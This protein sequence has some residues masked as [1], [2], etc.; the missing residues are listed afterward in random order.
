ME[1]HDYSIMS[2]SPCRRRRG[3]DKRPRKTEQERDEDAE[4]A[5]AH[6]D[7]HAYREGCCSQFDT[8][9]RATING[10]V[11]E[12]VRVMKFQNDLPKDCVSLATGSQQQQKRTTSL[13][14]GCDCGYAGW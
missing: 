10:E 9:L 12:P 11:V 5:Y 4:D 6:P 14:S 7:S 1:R 8:L 13:R 2:Q 3:E